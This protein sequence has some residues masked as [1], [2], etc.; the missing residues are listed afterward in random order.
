MGYIYKLRPKVKEF[1]L[2][3]KRA[4]PRLSSRE[5]TELVEDKFQLKLS[6]SSINDVIK[7]TGLSMS[8]GRR[9]KKKRRAAVSSPKPVSVEKAPQAPKTAPLPQPIIETPKPIEINRLTQIHKPPEIPK[10]LEPPKPSETANLPTLKPAPVEE[11]AT[12]AECSGAIILKAMDSLIGGSRFIVG[13]IKK[14][15]PQEPDILPKTEALIYLS[16]FIAAGQRQVMVPAPL[17]SLLDKEIFLEDALSYLNLLQSVGIKERE[18][19]SGISNLLRQVRGVKVILVGGKEVY[20]DAQFHTLWPMQLS[21]YSFCTTIYKIKSYINRYFFRDEPL[22]L[23]TAPDSEPPDEGL[24]NLIFGLD[25]QTAAI[26][27]LDIFGNKSEQLQAIGMGEKKKRPFIFGLWP[28]QYLDY[29]TIRKSGDF[30]PFNFEPL[31]KAFLLAEAEVTISQPHINQRVTL[32]GAILKNPDAQSS[33][34]IIVS[35][36]AAVEIEKIAAIYLERWPNLEEGLRDF[37]RKVESFSY[38]GDKQGVFPTGEAK[39]ADSP[40]DIKTFF[41]N[42]LA[43]LDSYFRWHFLPE[44]FRDK[45]FPTMKGLFYDLKAALKKEKGRIVVTLRTPPRFPFQKE[46]AYACCRLN[47]GQIEFGDGNRLWFSL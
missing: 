7:T 42:Y 13:E 46:L 41:S 18:L 31:K 24:F 1:L 5:L 17:R 4:N 9:V 21:P 11:V 26:S 39:P 22:V 37:M 32:R 15:L 29:R 45:D 2:K 28:G 23:F 35:N 16:L 38:L 40:A 34:L 25:S 8:V 14:H 19:S 43:I 36:I 20:L 44:E 27:R 47:E 6:K 3:E 33:I 30:R 12:E 10:P